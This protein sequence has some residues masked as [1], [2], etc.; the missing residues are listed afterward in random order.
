MQELRTVFA[1]P[2]NL[3]KRPTEETLFRTMAEQQLDKLKRRPEKIE[4]TDTVV[5][6]K[7]VVE[8]V[9]RKEPSFLTKLG[10]SF[11]SNANPVRNAT[12]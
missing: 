5:E 10:Q 12:A 2:V 9:V 7:P 3:S 11:S 6:E 1:P 4:S 8:D